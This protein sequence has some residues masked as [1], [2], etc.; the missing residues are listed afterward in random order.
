MFFRKDPFRV[1]GGRLSADP[2][3]SALFVFF[4]NSLQHRDKFD[5]DGTLSRQFEDVVDTERPVTGELL[6]RQ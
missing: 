5:S 6:F 4:Y 2:V 1:Y 3:T